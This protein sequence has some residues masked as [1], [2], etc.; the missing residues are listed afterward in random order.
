VSAALADKRLRWLRNRGLG[1]DPAP[2][3]HRR[4]LTADEALYLASR[5][6]E[7]A[8]HHA[9]NGDGDTA[10]SMCRLGDELAAAV[11]EDRELDALVKYTPMHWP[12]GAT[13]PVPNDWQVFG[14][15]S[16]FGLTPAGPGLGMGRAVACGDACYCRALPFAPSSTALPWNVLAELGGNVL[17]DGDLEERDGS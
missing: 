4:P 17:E 11:E 1:E 2:E 16:R 12:R 14:A 13:G 3:L 5:C 6:V 9:R 7:L 10:D 8:E 15:V